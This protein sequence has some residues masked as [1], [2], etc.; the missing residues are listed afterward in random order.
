MQTTLACTECNT[1][2]GVTR[3]PWPDPARSKTLSML[4]SELHGSWEI[5]SVPEAP[6]SGGTGKAQSHNPVAHA[7]EKSDTPVVP[8]KPSNKGKSPAEMVE[9]RGVAKGNASKN[10]VPRTPSRD[11]VASMGDRKSVV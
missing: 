4:G 9:E 2:H 1:V 5:S 10:P 6:E 8:E 7:D 11:K 3:E